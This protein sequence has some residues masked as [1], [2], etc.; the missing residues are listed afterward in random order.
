MKS[1]GRKAWLITWE[2]DHSKGF[3]KCKIVA[4]LSPSVGERNIKFLLP[5]LYGVECPYTLCE[6]MWFGIEPTG[7]RYLRQNYCDINSEFVYGDFHLYLC[8][9]KVKDIRCVESTKDDF[10]ST[11]FWTE[12]PKYILKVNLDRLGIEPEKYEDRIKMVIG[13]I[14]CQY[15]Y[16]THPV[17]ED[18]KTWR[19]ETKNPMG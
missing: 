15:T 7:I 11:L 17:I 14:E 12:L 6:K 19:A 3:G 10:E 18:E 4:I 1:K 13:E 9:R 8:A 16:S 2:G 5:S